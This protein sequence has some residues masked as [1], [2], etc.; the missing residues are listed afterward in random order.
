MDGAF[1]LLLIS[2]LALG[3]VMAATVIVIGLFGLVFPFGSS[4][5]RLLRGG[6]DGFALR[7]FVLAFVPIAIPVAVAIGFA[8]GFGRGLYSSTCVIGKMSFYSFF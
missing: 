7:L 2:G 5:S 8:L 6:L 3:A 1:D 4:L